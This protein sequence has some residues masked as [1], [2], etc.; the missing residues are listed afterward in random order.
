M[1]GDVIATV[2]T[3]VGVLLGVWRLVDGTKREL[4]AR[5]DALN[6]RTDSRFD[7]LNARIDAVLLKDRT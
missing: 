1:D 4:N 3:G 7:A 6:V 5:I 2:L